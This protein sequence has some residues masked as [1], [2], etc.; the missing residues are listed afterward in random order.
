MTVKMD[1]SDAAAVRHLLT[2]TQRFAARAEEARQRQEN[3]EQGQRRPENQRYRYHFDDF[4]NYDEDSDD[5]R[6]F[7]DLS[8]YTTIDVKTG[9]VTELWLGIIDV[10]GLTSRSDDKKHWTLS[11]SDWECLSQLDRLEHFKLTGCG[12]LPHRQMQRLKYLRHISCSECGN[13]SGDEAS[14]NK[15]VDDESVGV[16]LPQVK[17]ISLRC[18][19]QPNPAGIASLRAMFRY[20]NKNLTNL[21]RITIWRLDQQLM[22]GQISSNTTALQRK[23]YKRVLVETMLEELSGESSSETIGNKN[24]KTLELN[25]CG[26]TSA[27]FRQLMLEILPKQFPCLQ[28]LSLSSNEIDELPEIKHSSTGLM[29]KSFADKINEPGEDEASFAKKKRLYRRLR[30]SLEQIHLSNNPIM[31]FLGKNGEEDDKHVRDEENSDGE[32]D[33][34]QYQHDRRQQDE[35][36]ETVLRRFRRVEEFEKLRDWLRLLPRLSQL[37]YVSCMHNLMRSTTGDFVLTT[38]PS[39]AIADIVDSKGHG[40][41]EDSGIVVPFLHYSKYLQRQIEY[42][43]RINRGGRWL[44]D[45]GVFRGENTEIGRDTLLQSLALWPNILEWSYRTSTSGCFLVPLPHS[46]GMD[47]NSG[48]V[49]TA[50]QAQGATYPPNQYYPARAYLGSAWVPSSSLNNATALYNLLREGPALCG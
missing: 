42:Y 48:N 31:E 32:Q 19:F 13:L 21:E 47:R 16:P 39:T 25:R 1:P 10:Y 14:A 30:K 28:R 15:T 38:T 37:G 23:E 36:N 33:I 41:G 35:E 22:R 18:G 49:H 11:D 27:D 44:I 24:I 4:E 8:H 26:L 46:K 7:R 3:P 6:D 40:D 9:K 5:E 17:S 2:A 50:T 12:A 34:P 43:L 20:I 29:C 45:G